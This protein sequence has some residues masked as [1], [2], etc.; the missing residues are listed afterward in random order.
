MTDDV[1]TG[2]VQAA[3]RSLVESGRI[4]EMIEAKLGKLVESVLEDQFLSYN[5]EF[6]KQVKVALTE[7]IAFDPTTLNL[8]SYNA[9]IVDI[10]RRKFDAII[11]QR[12]RDG[13]SKMVDDLLREPPE[14]I[15]LSELV[16]EYKLHVRGYGNEKAGKNVSV[17]VKREERSFGS[18][19]VDIG[20]AEAPNL[21]SHDLYKCD[22]RLSSRKDKTDKGLRVFTAYLGTT[23]LSKHLFLGDVYGFER[24][25][26]QLW[27]AKTPLVLDEEAVDLEIPRDPDASDCDC[28]DNDD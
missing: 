25:L 7:A 6:G 22:F 24:K 11:D 27:A 8:P 2:A 4:N 12:A 3:M 1:L 10:L 23:D 28:H 13:M 18:E 14:E 20:L 17:V 16:E 9:V 26:F 19:W 21:T 5:G 15:K